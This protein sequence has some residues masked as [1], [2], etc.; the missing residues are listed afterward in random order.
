[1]AN[2][3][4]L[5]VV[6]CY[7]SFCKSLSG[8]ADRWKLMVLGKGPT[9]KSMCNNKAIREW[10][11]RVYVSI[12]LLVNTSLKIMEKSISIF[13]NHNVSDESKI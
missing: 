3:C 4:I 11:A 2:L 13:F 8:L 5:T 9:L 6:M 1:M 10:L 7:T 12:K